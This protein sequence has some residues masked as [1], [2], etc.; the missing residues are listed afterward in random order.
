MKQHWPTLA[1]ILLL[2]AGFGMLFYPDIANWWNG[3]ITA[4]LVDQ[5][6][7]DVAGMQA[8]QIEAHFER[9]DAHNDDLA[10][11][12]DSGA[13]VLI[14]PGI[15]PIPEDYTSILRVSGRMGHIRIPT[16]D[17]NIPIYHTTLDSA[18]DFGAGH[19]EGTS[20]P[21][22]G[23][24]THSVITA[25][26]ALAGRTLFTNLEGN[27]HVGHYFF[28]TVLDRTLQYRVTHIQQ[29]HPWEVEP[30]R[31]VPGED[32][33][34]LLTCTPYAI[35]TYRLLVTGTRV[36]YVPNLVEE[37]EPD[38]VSNSSQNDFRLY[39]FIGFF[40]IFMIGFVIYQIIIDTRKDEPDEAEIPATIPPLAPAA[41][42][43]AQHINKPLPHPPPEI[44]QDIQPYVQAIA[45]EPATHL[46]RVNSHQPIADETNDNHLPWSGTAPHEGLE[47]RKGSLLEQY[48][49]RTQGAGEHSYHT[50]QSPVAA[51]YTPA[52]RSAKTHSGTGILDKLPG[53]NGAK[54]IA[55]T[56]A[57]ALVLIIVVLSIALSSREQTPD[58]QNQIYG[59]VTRIEGHRATHDQLMVDEM[60]AHLREGGELAGEGNFDE[61]PFAEIMR[62]VKSHNR[63]LYESGQ[64]SL[65]DPFE[66]SQANA[67][68]ASFGLEEE[69]VGFIT[70]PG[71]GMEL[72]IFMGASENNLHRG[73]AHLTNTSLPVGGASTNAVIAGHMQNGR[74]NIL[75]GID[76]MTIGDEFEI[77]NFNETL[78]Y[79]VVDIQSIDPHNTN[80]LIIQSGRD[81]VTIVAYQNGTN[82][83]HVIIAERLL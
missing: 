61:E 9:A 6:T 22:G 25:H 29:V 46:P 64:P 13:P 59:F 31:I 11:L 28:I 76:R 83:R 15:G 43:A 66:Y 81:L 56:C 71:L 62:Q 63:Q 74:S 78:F 51:T 34:T 27:V 65:P 72:P 67:N 21:V 18:L 37:I 10:R 16:I 24:S 17:L 41:A 23:P 26:T 4:G 36:P 73:L 57:G 12:H 49:A 40:V 2:T 42:V 30:L 69:M 5:Y 3:R 58:M 47:T 52:R 48:I 77:T 35:N 7:R 39:I 54:L 14:G 82:M 68:L 1:V 32:L 75:N 60:L 53:T 20:L 70:I 44:T 8:A 45:P 33:V 55:A 38:F 50:R 80:P 19:L 79:T